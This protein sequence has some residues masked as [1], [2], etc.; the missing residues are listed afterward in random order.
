LHYIRISVMMRGMSADF[1]GTREAARL[2]GVSEASVRRWSDS[3]LLQSHRVG[4][5]SERRFERSVVLRLKGGGRPDASPSASSVLLEGLAI[6]VH[7]HLSSYYTSER[8]RLRLGVP[9]LRDG[10]AAGQPCVLMSDP[11]TARLLE[12][13]LKAEGVAVER[14]LQTGRLR[15]LEP[16]KTQSEGIEA[17]ERAFAEFTRRGDLLIRVLGE[18]TQNART[19]GSIAD[20]LRFEDVVTGLVRRYP[21]VMI[22]QYDVR[23]LEGTDV[24]DV[25]KVHADQFDQPLGM[26]LN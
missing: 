1:V 13:E 7:T 14:A 26:F 19:L 6:P 20:L 22:C 23:R 9:F 5:R 12:N 21:V 25:L 11:T 18:A 17:F 10:L 3:G 4:R 24:V 8:G 16:F 15:E 2:L